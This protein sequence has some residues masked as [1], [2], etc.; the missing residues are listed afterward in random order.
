MIGKEFC[1][2]KGVP[3]GEASLPSL[4]SCTSKIATL[5]P[6]PG[7][8][9]AW[10]LSRT[11]A[12][13]LVALRAPLRLPGPAIHSPNL[14]HMTESAGWVFFFLFNVMYSINR[15]SVVVSSW[16]KSKLSII[17]KNLLT[18]HWIQFVSFV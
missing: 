17:K 4:E 15:F 10:A 12:K 18:H 3:Q 14:G 11:E 1:D 9:L 13:N 5:C 6:P 7:C 16:D 8:P 2:Q